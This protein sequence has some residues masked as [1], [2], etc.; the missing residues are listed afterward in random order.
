M[1][2]NDQQITE[3][4][5]NQHMIDPFVPSKVRVN[6]RGQAVLSYG[7]SSF[8]YD[9]RLSSADIQ[10]LIPC[11]N[12][13]LNPKHF[14]DHFVQKLHMSKDSTY[15]QYVVLP[16]QGYMLGVSVEH[17][18]MPPDVIGICTGKSSYARAG[19]IINVTPLEPGWCGY[20]TLEVANQ[21]D[22]PV[23]VFLDEG[24]AQINFFKG[25]MPRNT[26][27]SG[28]YQEQPQSVVFSKV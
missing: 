14:K 4:C 18:K 5:L 23:M 12:V 27:G 25:D 13:K 6:D 26:Y 11:G 3:L 10:Q 24:I 17:F 9:I 20:L 28:K 22:S 15:G 8:G 7:L 21:T 16:P 19:I 1:I 2:L